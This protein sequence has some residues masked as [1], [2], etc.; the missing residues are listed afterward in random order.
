MTISS[1][2]SGLRT[3]G[4][5]ST[6]MRN[7]LKRQN[8]NTGRLAK[9]SRLCKL[10]TSTLA[11]SDFHSTKLPTVVKKSAA[12]QVICTGLSRTEDRR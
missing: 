5:A 2:S 11:H 3:Y 6:G 1:A 7:R 10:S 4:K 12:T 9:N 8:K